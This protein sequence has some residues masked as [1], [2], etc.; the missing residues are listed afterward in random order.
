MQNTEFISNEMC[1][2]NKSANSVAF[3][4][5]FKSYI[6]TGKPIKVMTKSH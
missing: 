6:F 2:M 5:R 3:K 4:T 1:P